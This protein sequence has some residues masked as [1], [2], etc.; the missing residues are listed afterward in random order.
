MSVITDVK[1]RVV[2]LARSEK[3][4]YSGDEERPLGGYTAAMAVYAAV[5]GTLAG[6]TR[7]T[8][9]E[10]PDGL[11]VKDVALLVD[12]LGPVQ[13]RRVER[14]A[15]HPDYLLHR[16]FVLERRHCRFTYFSGRPG[17]RN[18]ESHLGILPANAGSETQRTGVVWGRLSVVKQR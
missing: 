9:H 4:R 1:S 16:G 12:R 10:V 18:G 7:L 5:A 17:D 11:A 13:R 6:V 2:G 8:R 14:P 3:D 15:R